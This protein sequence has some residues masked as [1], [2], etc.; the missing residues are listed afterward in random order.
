[1]RLPEQ[2][3]NLNAEEKRA[4]VLNL[5][6]KCWYERTPKIVNHLTDE[7]VDFL[8]NYVFT[9][10]KEEREK[11]WKTIQNKY[12]TAVKNLKTIA[13]RLQKLDLQFAELLAQKKDAEEFIKNIK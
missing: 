9:E 3:K 11:M 10:S 5:I 6:N 1:M 4:I 13:K 2:Y 7:Q 12:E 8:F